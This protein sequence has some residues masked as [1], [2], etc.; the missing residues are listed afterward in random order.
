MI[1]PTVQ[2]L[3]AQA[4]II[5]AAVPD[6]AQWAAFIKRLGVVCAESDQQRYELERSHRV[7]LTELR[8][9]QRRMESE[10][11]TLRQI[12]S[13]LDEGLIAVDEQGEVLFTN[14]AACLLLGLPTHDTQGYNLDSLIKINAED[15]RDL[16]SLIADSASFPTDGR[17][18]L[19]GDQSR[20]IE[21]VMRSLGAQTGAR[22]LT[23]QDVTDR[24][25]AEKQLRESEQRFRTLADA[26]PVMIWTTGADGMCDYVNR[27]WC[28]FTGQQMHDAAD[29]GWVA[30]LHPDE[31]ERV[32]RTYIEALLS[33]M[34]IRIEH[35]LCR[36][37]GEYAMVSSRGVPRYAPGGGFLGH[38]G[39]ITDITEI[40]RAEVIEAGQ[41][42]V[43]S[44][45]ATDAGLDEV[46]G[47]IVQLVDAIEP[48]LMCALLVANGDGKL[49]LAAEQNLPDAWSAYLAAGITP[50]PE[51]G[52]AGAAAWQRARVIVEDIRIDP[53]CVHNRERALG[54]GIGCSWA[55]PIIGTQGTVL[56]VVTLHARGPRRPGL[57][58]RG[59]ME[60]AAHLAQVVIERR[61]TEAELAAHTADLLV[62]KGDLEEQAR[63]LEHARNAAEAAS[64]AKSEFLANMSHEIRTPMT[65]VLGYADLVL[66]PGQDE[67][68]RVE[69]VQTIRRNAEHLLT[70]LN[71]ILDVSKIEAGRMSVERISVDPVRI[72]DEVIVLM[73]PKA[74]AKGIELAANFA[75]PLP[76]KIQSDPVRLRQILLNLISNAIKFTERGRVEV[77][78]SFARDA[79]GGRLIFDVSDTGIGMSEATI[80]TLFRPFAQADAS[81]TRRFG[82]TGLGLMVS[83]T[84]A[85]LLG[86]GIAV[87][88]EE[89][90]GSTFTASVDCGDLAAITLVNAR[91]IQQAS[92]DTA[93]AKAPL[94]AR[95]LL[96]E[97]GI[98][99]QRLISTLLRRAGAQ[100][101]IAENGRIAVD[102][103]MAADAPRFDVILMDMQMPELDGYS[104][105]RTLRE[106]G[107]TGPIIALTAH[108]MAED[109]ARCIAA[110]CDDYATKPID[111]VTLIA[112][113][114][115]WAKGRGAA[116][117]SP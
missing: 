66:A 71:D 113:C 2:R 33:R 103:V 19:K 112:M 47:E 92:A 88:S 105:A 54:C 39:S 99:N 109:R 87:R 96:A 115:R 10:R 1:H 63:E 27:H 41:N 56:G 50:G 23:L 52:A 40:K 86:G 90:K 82:G 22:L 74:A 26:A 108:A 110:G 57:M 30:L 4:G 60:T 45:L 76:A 107:Y 48:G 44:T 94:T 101:E 55:E 84:L 93:A 116:A 21:F 32:A 97:D 79:Q 37:N 25:R 14:P 3:L 6:T 29:D 77:R 31:R 104:A 62:A 8:Q 51:S 69:C 28:E 78:V 95:I 73:A 75:W 64:R 18:M 7:T 12:T 11:D 53:I 70:V 13:A 89:G 111:R 35:R 34:P 98:D 46:L 81:T 15:G 36:A 9:M 17:L 85:E 65:A 102:K 42:R 49:S 61:R 100:V 106:M 43:L 67:A 38:I 72:V 83:R 5:D 16:A 117:P 59:L 20:H 24:V 114:E 91:S 58:H 80:G 68:S